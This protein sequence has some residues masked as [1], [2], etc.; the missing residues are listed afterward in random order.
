MNVGVK[1]VKSIAIRINMIHKSDKWTETIGM[2]IYKC[3]D[4]KRTTPLA[5]I[6]GPPVYVLAM[7][8]EYTKRANCK[9]N[10]GIGK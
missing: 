10:D 6:E 5:T 7:L 4:H 2:R 8:D 3:S 9:Y 1:L